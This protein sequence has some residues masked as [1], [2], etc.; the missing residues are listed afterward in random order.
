MRT[1]TLLLITVLLFSCQWSYSQLN[2]SFS[3]MDFT[4]NPQW[5]GN[6]ESFEVLNPPTTGDGS[7]DNSWLPDGHMLRSTPGAGDAVLVTASERAYGEWLFSIAD[8]KGWSVSSTND[9]YIILMSD[10]DNTDLLTDGNMD[11]NGYFLRFDG[12]TDDNFILYKQTGTT[13]TAILNSEFPVGTDGTTSIPFSVKLTRTTEGLWTLYM[14][15]GLYLDAATPRG[16]ATDNDITSSTFFGIGTNISN[17]GDVR[18]LY[19][20]NIITRN[21]FIDTYPPY[22][23]ELSFS[24][25]KSIDLFFDELTEPISA[26]AALNYNVQTMGTPQSATF[27]NGLADRVRISFD[28][29]F[30][31]GADLMIAVTGVEDLNGNA[32]DTTFQFT[33]PAFLGQNITESF[34]D[35]NLNEN[36]TWTGET[37]NFEISDPI[38][39]GDG[40]FPT[41]YDNDGAVLQSKI[42]T[43][44][45][46]IALETFRAYGQ[47]SF[48]I[49][50]GAG[51]S[52]SSTNDFSIILMADTDNP[53][54]LK[55]GSMNF[56]GYYLRFDGSNNDSFVLHKQQGTTSTSIIETNYPT[57][58]D[59]SSPIPYTVKITRSEN[60]G[61]KLFI[62]E[63]FATEPY[64]LRG[65][66][67]DNDISSAHFFGFST[68]INTPSETRVAYIDEIYVGE[69]IY[70]TEPPALNRIK[71]LSE[72]SISLQFSEPIDTT[73]VNET[74][75]IIDSNN[76]LA[77]IAFRNFGTQIELR[78]TNEF[79]IREEKTLSITGI[80]DLEGNPMNDTTAS[81][82]YFSVVEG[83]V[84]INEVFF[85]TYPQVGLPDYDFIELYNR[86][87]FDVTLENWTLTI[88]EDEQVFPDIL[89][90][91]NEYLIITSSA[92]EEEYAEF[93]NVAGIITTTMLTNAGKRIVLKDSLGTRLHSITYNENWYRDPD[94]ADGGWS[95]EQIDP[96]SWCAQASNWRASTNFIGGTPGAIN[97]VD[98]ENSDNTP[99]A[100]AEIGIVDAQT[101]AILFTE[102]V[103]A[104]EINSAHIQVDPMP[105]TLMYSQSES[106]QNLWLLS[107]SADIPTR[108]AITFSFSN[109]TDFCGNALTN[110][111][112]TTYRLL[113]EFQQI[114]VNEI[115]AQ[116]AE[117]SGFTYEYIELYNRDTLPVNIQNYTLKA[118]SR[119]WTLPTASI[120]SGGYLL[121]LPE[122]MS[123]TDT[124]YTN[125]VYL[126]QESSISDNG[127]LIQLLG[128][129]EQII[130]WVDYSSSWHTNER[131]AMGGYALERIDTENLCNGTSNWITAENDQHGTPGQENSVAATNSDITN[132]VANYYI[133]PNDS[134]L[135]IEFDSPIWP[136]TSLTNIT[137]TN[138]TIMNATVE[139]PYGNIL[140]LKPKEKLTEGTEYTVTL[141]GYTD[142]NQN[143]ME[144]ATFTFEKPSEPEVGDIIINEVLFDAPTNCNDFVEIFNMS[145]N[146]LQLNQLFLANMDYNDEPDDVSKATETAYVLPPNAY[147]IL[148]QEYECI[149]ENYSSVAKARTISTTLPSM[150][151]EEG[152][153][154][155][156]DNTGNTID[157]MRYTSDMHHSLLDDPDGVSLERISPFSPADNPSNWYSAAADAGF[158]TPTR[159]NSHYNAKGIAENNISLQ[160]K[161]FSPD[162]DGFQDFLTINYLFKTGNNV[163]NIRIL[164]QQG[165]LIN[166]L[167]NN[168]TVSVE[169]FVT[170]DGTDDNAHKQQVGVYIIHS[171]WYD[172]NG[173][174]KTDTRT[175]VLAGGLK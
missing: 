84:V 165:Q 19:I 85:D 119:S 57:G 83:D 131:Y 41:S 133:V 50:D 136:D 79:P 159:E 170:W 161:T 144:T 129:D 111:T 160:N 95:I 26:Q 132:P 93:G 23:T 146:Y 115:M 29:S 12:G 168:E 73:I 32:I 60:D 47:W 7:I 82:T 139:H 62:D 107:S 66:S 61:W 59:G 43:E 20:D 87:G 143:E 28:E 153:I 56:N 39:E 152:S 150:A 13:S 51:W 123:T 36:P 64:T 34:T 173:N 58:T 137:A 4:T 125:A 174:Q 42:N 31:G 45:S 5:T 16:S 68:N 35:L 169:G 30:E 121:V 53:Q 167:V 40:A 54:M 114:I 94:K 99:P 158:A 9:F 138:M 24:S 3:D 124:E 151:N 25:T 148:T 63:G 88:G 100:I 15:E 104:T 122:S 166:H 71:V 6:T 37:D 108:T 135:Q 110:T 52:V 98:D 120:P 96:E 74:N 116:P 97:A 38:T 171:E 154:M 128:S 14:D 140:N 102:E 112:V 101:I 72:N 77:N 75:F 91:A 147:Y 76:E 46:A 17:P 69:I 117:S 22:I 105:G 92:A 156:L 126:M 162:G 145:D 21:I 55:T 142:C 89:L 86:S 80:A 65:T 130:D 78:Y 118:G 157:A 127:T 33:T 48:S 172:E 11:F 109:I 67:S 18:T 44:S 134:T 175:C 103:P 10:T 2:E 163:L 1:S 81:F 113:P 106:N 149:N 8:G 164:D 90:A 49:V 70:D 155:L 141:N 27:I